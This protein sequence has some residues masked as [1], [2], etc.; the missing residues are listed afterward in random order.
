MIKPN[1]K[2]CT[3]CKQIKYLCLFPKT[4]RA[5]DGYNSWCLDCKNAI[6]DK[7]RK[8]TADEYR[9]AR[10]KERQSIQGKARRYIEN[11][12]R[13]G[14]LAKS[15]CQICGTLKVQAHHPDYSKPSDI[16]W[17]CRSH[18]MAWHRLFL[19]EGIFEGVKG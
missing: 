16:M 6:P 11:R 7:K 9:A 17:L 10:T 18:H 14:T 8:L 3:H 13:R 2:K 1:S 19:A 4:R 12:V 15:P 5:K